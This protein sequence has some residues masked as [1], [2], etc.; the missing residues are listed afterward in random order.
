[1]KIKQ[2]LMLQNNFIASQQIQ[3]EAKRIS[4]SY[5]IDFTIFLL[6]RCLHNSKVLSTLQ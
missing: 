4:L 3:P 6:D 5:Q 2:D 1:M